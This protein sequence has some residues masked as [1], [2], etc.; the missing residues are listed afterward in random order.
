MCVPS[1]WGHWPV[2]L[3]E[4]LP[5]F[6]ERITSLETVS[7]E[8]QFA[9]ALTSS[10]LRIPHQSAPGYPSAQR[11]ACG[12]GGSPQKNSSGGKDEADWAEHPAC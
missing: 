5:S 6:G 3:L 2:T 4:A 10:L 12:R 11:V 7:L 9:L 8:Q 1:V